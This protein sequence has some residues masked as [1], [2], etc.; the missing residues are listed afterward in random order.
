M[1]T[2]SP[3]LR[4]RKKVWQG[5]PSRRRVRRLPGRSTPPVGGG[6]PGFAFLHRP[7]LG[8]GRT[9][10]QRVYG[11]A[12]ERGTELR[13]V[14]SQKGRGPLWQSGP[15]RKD[16][17]WTCWRFMSSVLSA[18]SRGASWRPGSRRDLRGSPQNRPSLAR[19]R[20]GVP[21]RGLRDLPQ[22][23]G[24]QGNVGPFAPEGRGPFSGSV[25][26]DARTRY[27]APFQ[28]GALEPASAGRSR[29]R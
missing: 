4:V 21:R 16:R 22:M 10:S 27:D 2:V 29:C 11:I 20:E 6:A 14:V 26:K 15:R 1:R 13:V 3:H 12:C 17:I 28:G 19:S 25:L 7:R 24:S 8:N 5:S 9:A 23:G 18:A